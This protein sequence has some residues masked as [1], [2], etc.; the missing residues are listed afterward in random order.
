MMLRQLGGIGL[1][2]VALALPGCTRTV[3]NYD[4]SFKLEDV[5]RQVTRRLLAHRY[6]RSLLAS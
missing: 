2:A 3:L 4:K 5:W 1:L 6:S